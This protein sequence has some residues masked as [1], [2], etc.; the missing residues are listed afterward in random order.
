MSLLISSEFIKNNVK[1]ND[2]NEKYLRIINKD[3]IKSQNN[4]NM[5]TNFETTTVMLL[6]EKFKL[7][8]DRLRSHMKNTDELY[9]M[10][11]RITDRVT[12]LEKPKNYV[13]KSVQTIPCFIKNEYGPDNHLFEIRNTNNNIENYK[14]N[15]VLL[16]SNEVSSNVE[17]YNNLNIK[18]FNQNAYNSFNL[19]EENFQRQG[20]LSKK[21]VITY[22]V[23]GCRKRRK[24][25][26]LKKNDENVHILNTGL[27]DNLSINNANFYN[28]ANGNL[29]Y[30]QNTISDMELSSH[31]N[32]N[33]SIQGTPIKT[34]DTNDIK[35]INEK[36]G[37]QSYEYQDM[38]E[39]QNLLN[40]VN[41]IQL[42]DSP[43][44]SI[45]K[46]LTQSVPSKYTMLSSQEMTQN[47]PNLISPINGSIINTRPN[48]RIHTRS[49][50]SKD[51][52]KDTKT[53]AINENFSNYL[54]PINSL[55]HII[56]L[57]NEDI[58]LNNNKNDQ[59]FNSFD[60]PSKIN[61]INMCSDL[62]IVD[63]IQYYTERGVNHIEQQSLENNRKRGPAKFKNKI[64]LFRNKVALNRKNKFT[65]SSFNDINQANDFID[66]EYHQ[67]ADDAH[68]NISLNN[69]SSK[70]K[71]NNS[72]CKV[73]NNLV[74]NQQ[75]KETVS[76]QSALNIPIN[77]GKMYKCK[78]CKK[79]FTTPHGRSIHF[80]I[81]HKKVST[82]NETESSFDVK[83]RKK[84]STSVNPSKSESKTKDKF[85][86][87]ANEI[88]TKSQ[89][90]SQSLTLESLNHLNI[91]E[92]NKI[93]DNIV[94]N[95]NYYPSSN[96]VNKMNIF[97]A[98]NLQNILAT[99]ID[100]K[101]LANLNVSESSL[102]RTL[103][104]Y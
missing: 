32:D 36:P 101:S 77:N 19:L 81:M 75:N 98:P 68:H 11:L 76:K 26:R 42:N 74:I 64:A 20:K 34:N 61:K 43:A 72:A 22:P 78:T 52:I 91:N 9:H 29:E 37:S 103:S 14:N 15:N 62:K 49:L 38:I 83:K 58:N 67:I 57:C 71:S 17:N 60:N 12:Q 21:P 70:S 95:D 86:Y 82:T 25:V 93:G 7:M 33:I 45:N 27:P 63:D 35:I 92:N 48:N 30:K 28:N 96:T 47:L 84:R 90:Y 89:Q 51:S 2:L 59:I 85:I 79:R 104:L 10:A 55:P 39:R 24:T 41:V 102:K 5:K 13:S 50:Q 46:C 6:L 80:S 94:I 18:N 4:I 97:T 31:D 3:F 100:I 1:T 40:N 16:Y 66:L 65:I 99:N 8:Q 44:K 56:N 69:N 53:L 73:K 23:F 88:K 54:N 87:R